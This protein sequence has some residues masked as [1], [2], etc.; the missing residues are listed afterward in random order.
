MLTYNKLSLVVERER[1][2]KKEIIANHYSHFLILF[3]WQIFF[4]FVYFFI[5][6]QLYFS[7]NIKIFLSLFLSKKIKYNFLP[8]YTTNYIYKICKNNFNK[9]SCSE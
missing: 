9:L 7:K 2:R 5:L 8:C 3:N 1:K 4:S 6:F